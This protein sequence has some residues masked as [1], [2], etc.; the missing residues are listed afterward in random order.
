[1]AR[2]TGQNVRDR[3]RVQME[4]RQ[5]ERRQIAEMSMTEDQRRAMK[6]VDARLSVLPIIYENPTESVTMGPGSS[7]R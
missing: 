1:M 5:D 7:R 6:A 2:L 4:A 3:I